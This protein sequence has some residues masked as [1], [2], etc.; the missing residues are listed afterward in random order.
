LQYR[1]TN[2]ASINPFFSKTVNECGS[3]WSIRIKL[4]SI[5]KLACLA[6][7]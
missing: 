2:Y 6:P 4:I 5:K 1:L 3:L 7:P